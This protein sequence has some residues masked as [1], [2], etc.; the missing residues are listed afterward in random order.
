MMV[1]P[2]GDFRP[3]LRAGCTAAAP[4]GPATADGLRASATG[5]PTSPRRRRCASVLRRLGRTARRRASSCRRGDRIGWRAVGTFLPLRCLLPPSTPETDP[6]R[7]RRGAWGGACSACTVGCQAGSAAMARSVCGSPPREARPPLHV[8]SARRRC[9]R[10]AVAR[11]VR[12]VAA[13][14]RRELGLV[15]QAV[16]GWR[17]TRRA[18][19]GSSFAGAGFSLWVLPGA[20]AVTGHTGPSRASVGAGGRS[21]PAQPFNAIPGVREPCGVLGASDRAEGPPRDGEPSVS[22]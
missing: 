22:G 2:S 8:T 10:R 6:F 5:K 13:G 18:V 19:A 9:A 12:A 21:R 20:W 4:A 7:R 14:V 11:R 1:P 3:D 16:R 17:S 15:V